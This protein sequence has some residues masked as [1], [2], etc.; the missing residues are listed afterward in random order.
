MEVTSNLLGNSRGS[1]AGKV[2]RHMLVSLETKEVA[3]QGCAN[4]SLPACFHMGQTES[5]HLISNE[6]KCLSSLGLIFFLFFF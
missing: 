4:V 5:L 6:L 1:A 2:D 3:T